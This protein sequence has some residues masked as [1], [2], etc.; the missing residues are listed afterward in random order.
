MDVSEYEDGN[1]RVYTRA[2]L[3]PRD[4]GLVMVRALPFGETTESLMKSIE[5]AARSKRIAVRGLTDY[6]TGDVEIEI[7]TDPGAETDDILRGLY[8]FTSCEVAIS[9]NLLVI[10]DGHPRVMTVS[11]MIRHS[12][13]LLLEILEAELKIEE[14]DLRAQLPGPEARAGLHRK[15]YIQ[16]IEDVEDIEGVYTA[17][18]EAI[19]RYSPVSTT[20]RAVD[21]GMI[22]LNEAPPEIRDAARSLLTTVY[23]S[24]D[25]EHY[26][27]SREMIAGTWTRS[28]TDRKRIGAWCGRCWRQSATNSPRRGAWPP[29]K[30]SSRPTI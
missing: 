1:G 2:R 16:E 12:T 18:R 3:E 28:A 11:D 29:W 6:T 8:A 19:A 27:P 9:A 23:R 20:A 24:L 13:N 14:R 30:T 22:E 26:G 25:F 5:E 4:D 7:R 15:P 21:R 10:S 17:V